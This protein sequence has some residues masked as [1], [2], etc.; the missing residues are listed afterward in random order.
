LAQD[1]LEQETPGPATGAQPVSGASFTSASRSWNRF[2]R[3]ALALVV[4]V[5]I[6]L[7][8]FLVSDR[9]EQFGRYGY[10]GIFVLSLLANATIIIPAPSLAV[11]TIM[12]SVLNPFAVGACAGAGEALGELTGYLA[13]Y[14]GRAVIENRA[15]YEQLAKWT[16]RYG[17]WVIFVLSVIPN[18][19]FDLAGIAAG[20]LKIPVHRFL[21][22]C[23]IGKT[24]KTTLFA[25]GGQG[26]AG[27]LP[28]LN[29]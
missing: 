11:V 27:L 14:S 1:T 8:V 9:V 29:G 23:W 2:V 20:A 13:G 19:L 24:I 25:L 3:P 10:P 12:G 4:A 7:S 21:V 22:A 18:P 6:S 15:R 16:H 26:V 5:G 17:L 28:F